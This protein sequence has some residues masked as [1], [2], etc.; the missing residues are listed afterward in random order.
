MS[1]RG[2]ALV[3]AAFLS[4]GAAQPVNLDALVGF[5]RQGLC[6][7]TP[8]FEALI[9][10]SYRSVDVDGT[11]AARQPKVAANYRSAFGKVRERRSVQGTSI[12]LP[13]RNARWG[14]LPIT[15]LSFHFPAGGDPP[16]IFLQF[17]STARQLR[18]SL[19]AKH[20]RIGSADDG[21][22]TIEMTI[23]SVTGDPSSVV[24][25]CATG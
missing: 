10:S 1:V 24:L 11:V 20:I 23:S 25:V 4:V 12:I 13:L 17:R 15:Q 2:A 14:G 5:E 18:A 3:G 22:Y 9:H 8:T 7:T 19:A 16:Q 6:E 21:V